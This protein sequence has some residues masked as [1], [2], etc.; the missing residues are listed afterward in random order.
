MVDFRLA[1][2]NDIPK[3][4]ELLCDDFIGNIREDLSCMQGYEYAFEEIKKD[5]N[6]HLVVMMLGVNI[7]G[8]FHLTIIPSLS[9]RGSKRGSLESVRIDKKERNKGFGTKM[10]TYA[11]NLA[12]EKGAVFVQ[13]TTNKLRLDAIRFYQTL[14]F[15][16]SHEGL[17]FQF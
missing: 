12:K 10:I 14:G 4:V 16:A 5:H 9:D 15:V 17:K 3:M 1:T 2:I 11:V 6:Q 13:L 8:M 7:I